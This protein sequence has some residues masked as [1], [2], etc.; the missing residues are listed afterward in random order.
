MNYTT[1]ASWALKILSLVPIIANGIHQTHADL[2]LKGKQT[3]AQDALAT[4]TAS[5]Q[6]L[7][8]ADQAALASSIA[9]VAA[10]SLDATVAALHNAK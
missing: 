5:A 1:L 7:L 9:S 2:D 10:Q 8:P 3:A 6:V 4:A